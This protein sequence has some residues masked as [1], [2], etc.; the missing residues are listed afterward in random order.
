MKTLIILTIINILF[1]LNINA[2][3]LIISNE[4]ASRGDD[5]IFDISIND[6]LNDVKSFGFDI[7]P[8]TSLTIFWF[9]YCI[10]LKQKIQYVVANRVS[11]VV[12]I[13]C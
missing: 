10:N 2:D 1:C 8:T 11:D 7:N 9:T 5:V 13:I 3:N 12:G 4:A 6:A